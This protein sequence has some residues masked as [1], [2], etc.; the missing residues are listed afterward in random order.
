MATVFTLTN[1]YFT[2]K[3]DTNGTWHAE[4]STNT[5]TSQDDGSIVLNVTQHV[6]TGDCPI[7]VDNIPY[8]VTITQP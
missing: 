5:S 7:S 6:T 4:G 8:T 2:T 3:T 1:V